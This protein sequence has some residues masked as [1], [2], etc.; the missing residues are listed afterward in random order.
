MHGDRALLPFI[1]LYGA[2]S[3][4]HFV[5]NALYINAYPNLPPWL[6]PAGVYA[7]WLGIAGIG[8]SGYWLYRRGSRAVGLA[9]IAIYALLGF[10]GLDHYALAPLSAHSRAMNA[11]ILGEV[12]AASV[13]LI[14]IVRIAASAALHKELPS[15]SHFV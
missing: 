2:V 8:A 1:I 4:V 9:V 11:T 10:G 3:L 5:H 14:V 7:A 13:L 12:T 15:R 6:T